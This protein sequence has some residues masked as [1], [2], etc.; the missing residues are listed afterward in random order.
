MPIPRPTCAPGR[1]AWCVLIVALLLTGLTTALVSRTAVA[2]DRL[3]FDAATQRVADALTDG[4]ETCAALLRGIAG[5]YAAD[6]AVD[7]QDFHEYVNR[8]DLSRHYPGIRGVGFAALTRAGDEASLIERMRLS[9]Q[10]DFRVWPATD[11]PDRFVIT[12]LEP[13]DERNRAA[14]GFDMF[15]DPARRAAMER[16]RDTALPAASAPVLL[17]QEIDPQQCR[18]FLLY[19]PV[20]RQSDAPDGAADRRGSLLG[21][22]YSPFRF[23]DLIEGILLNHRRSDIDI[24]VYDGD[25]SPATLLRDWQV[26]PADRGRFGWLS[27]THTIKVG[28]RHWTLRFSA[29]PGFEGGSASGLVPLTMAAG[30]GVSIFLFGSMWM[31]EASRRR[32]EATTARLRHSEAELRVSESRF[33]RLS[34]SNIVG[35][36][37]VDLDGRVIDGNDAMFRIFGRRREEM[38]GGPVRW[39][40]LTPP[41]SLDVDARVVAELRSRGRSAAFEKDYLHADGRRVTVLGAAA[42]LEG[43][44]E[45]CIAFN[46]D[47][48]KLKRAE[49]DLA[50]AKEAAEASNRA[51]DRFLAVL[52]HELR[53]PLTPVLALADLNADDPE[54]SEEQREDWATVARNVQ[55]E[56]KL[57]E[58]LLDVTRIGRGKI[59]FHRETLDLHALLS[60]LTAPD[61]GTAKN[62][63][64][65]LEL[66][67]T[68]H[69][70][71]GDPAR[72]GQVFANLLNNA[73]KFSLEGGRIILRTSSG[74]QGRVRVEVVDD[75]IGIDPALLP[76]VFEAFEQGE[77]QTN[78]VYGG[79]G[80]GLAIAKNFVE[81]HGGTIRVE[82]AGRGRGATFAVELKTIG[83]PS[84]NGDGPMPRQFATRGAFDGETVRSTG[85]A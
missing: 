16:A 67:A 56:A 45:E 85:R 81:A 84:E 76:K 6:G 43:A 55:W 12:Q 36:G 21:F 70:V 63:S 72:L 31:Q 30:V 77:G 71:F 61:T 78:R 10:A 66:D 23:G 28:G 8:L 17:K 49:R 60:T 52:S 7:R 48:T 32:A 65:S 9:G 82:S 3:R 74:D 44:G 13:A 15:T 27:R 34:E 40:E 14:L 24:A 26:N 1:A 54:A 62:L 51:K 73:A 47:I 64:L 80:L 39:S 46:V 11:Q 20:Y 69:H 83:D 41:E 68:H 29:L 79:L 57:I 35:I 42:M 37:I 19:V 75:G 22:A 33:R 5:L 25:P 58:D 38:V 2:K 53:N 18:G 59:S 50:Q 4:M